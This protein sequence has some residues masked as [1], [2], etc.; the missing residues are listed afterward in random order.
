MLQFTKTKVLRISAVAV[1]LLGL[2]ALAGFV[3]VPR[4]LR[5]QLM[6]NIPKAL[7]A[8]PAVGEIRFNPFSF[9]LEIKALSLSAR[10][11]EKLLGFERLFVDFELSSLWH[12]AYSFANIDLDSPYV[13]AIVAND[14][15]LNLL[16]LRPSTAPG[17]GATRDEAR[18]VAGAAHWVVQGQRG[19]GGIRRSQPTLR[20]RRALGTDQLSN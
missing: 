20:V 15:N 6:E 13:N 10:N 16:Q 18:N 17:K 4:V 7:G 5:S 8:T 14:G 1:L 11:G 19:T 3:F 9:Q 12:R 2:Y